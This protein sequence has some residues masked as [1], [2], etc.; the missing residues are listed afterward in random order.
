ME[1]PDLDA[2]VSDK[3]EPDLNFGRKKW[4]FDKKSPKIN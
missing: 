1:D 4:S 2:S 3:S